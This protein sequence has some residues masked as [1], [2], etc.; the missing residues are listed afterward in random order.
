MIPGAMAA[1][2][3]STGLRLE[4]RTAEPALD[5]RA[6]ERRERAEAAPRA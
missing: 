3:G 4:L 1:D 5:D 6:R 2:G